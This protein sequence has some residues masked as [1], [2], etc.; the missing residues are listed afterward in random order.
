[1]EPEEFLS[2]LVVLSGDWEVEKKGDW[3]HKLLNQCLFLRDKIKWLEKQLKKAT[4][5]AK[6]QEGKIMWLE[7]HVRRQLTWPVRRQLS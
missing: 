4:A 6:K 3:E 5:K 1:M 7:K 2:I